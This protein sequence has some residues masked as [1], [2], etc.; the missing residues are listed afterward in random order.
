MTVLVLENCPREGGGSPFS[1]VP[2]PLFAAPTHKKRPG[3][4]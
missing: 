2:R 3:K 4:Q 1:L